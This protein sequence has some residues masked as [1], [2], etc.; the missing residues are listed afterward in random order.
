LKFDRNAV[1]VQLV[2]ATRLSV[3][4]LWGAPDTFKNNLKP[5]LLV[6]LIPAAF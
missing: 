3:E 1:G 5:R 6:Q 4:G 2:Q